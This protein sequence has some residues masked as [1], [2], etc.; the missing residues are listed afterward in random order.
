[1]LCGIFCCLTLIR[2]FLFNIV[3]T[4]IRNKFTRSP[5]LTNACYFQSNEVKNSNAMELTG[6]KRCL[7][8]LQEKSMKVSSLTTDRHVQVKKYMRTEKPTI[9]HWFD[10]WHV[11]KGKVVLLSYSFNRVIFLFFSKSDLINLQCPLVAGLDTN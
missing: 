10:V 3:I 11:A 6:L 5:N 2:V 8:F 4:F 9:Q 1:M 7:T